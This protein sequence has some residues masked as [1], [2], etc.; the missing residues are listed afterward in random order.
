MSDFLRPLVIV[1]AAGFGRRVGSPESKEMLLRE[2]GSYLIDFALDW[3]RENECRC[4]VLTRKEKKNLIDYLNA[5]SKQQ[6]LQISIVSET[7]DWPETLLL[8]AP[9]W[10]KWNLVFLPDMSFEPRSALKDGLTLFKQNQSQVE[11]EPDLIVWSHEISEARSSWGYILSEGPHKLHLAEKPK[12]DRRG[13]AW[14]LYAFQS[15]IG[16]DLL[17]AQAASNR[18]HEWKMLALKCKEVF[19]ESFRDLTRGQ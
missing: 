14:G 15:T 1:P 5:K 16:L 3:A 13:R 10:Q 2:D 7:R 11:N 4:L 9:Y 19:L 6:D 18:D 17:R 8:S 12:Q